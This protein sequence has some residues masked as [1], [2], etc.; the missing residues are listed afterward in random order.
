VCFC[1]DFTLIETDM[2]YVSSWQF[3]A[4]AIA[5]LFAVMSFYDELLQ[6]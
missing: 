1:G 2:C 6:L 4:Y 5:E 3:S